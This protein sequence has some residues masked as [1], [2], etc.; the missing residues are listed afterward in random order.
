MNGLKVFQ[1]TNTVISITKP[2]IEEMAVKLSSEIKNFAE[3]LY[4][5]AEKYPSLEDW[6]EVMEKSLEKCLHTFLKIKQE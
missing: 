2:I 5:L 1:T 4:V 6:A 3:K